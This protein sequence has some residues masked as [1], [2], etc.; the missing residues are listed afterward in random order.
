MRKTVLEQGNPQE[1]V[2]VLP[3]I[4]TGD[5]EPSLGFVPYHL[6]K[7]RITFFEL[8]THKNH[9]FGLSKLDPRDREAIVAYASSRNVT[10]DEM[11]IF[12]SRLLRDKK[13]VSW[14]FVG[15][16]PK[17]VLEKFKVELVD[18]LPDS[19]RV[20]LEAHGLTSALVFAYDYVGAVEVE[21]SSGCENIY[22]HISQTRLKQINRGRDAISPY[23]LE[24]ST[25]H[26][27]VMDLWNLHTSH[28]SKFERIL[29]RRI[30]IQ[31]CYKYGHILMPYVQAVRFKAKRHVSHPEYI[32]YED[33]R[34]RLLKMFVKHAHTWAKGSI[35][36]VHAHKRAE[37]YVCYHWSKDLYIGFIQP[38]CTIYKDVP[39]RVIWDASEG[40]ET[41]IL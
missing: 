37:P 4:W 6:D 25:H 2:R 13:R 18:I 10:Y 40:V 17:K 14:H 34:D 16:P 26:I 35:L 3:H 9:V 1:S 31:S 23:Q 20:L 36:Y 29:Q 41:W 24:N 8:G 11:W 22:D 30:P 5:T 21:R 12:A 7:P 28:H 39:P 38:R 27:E 15:D 33:T 32:S 19:I